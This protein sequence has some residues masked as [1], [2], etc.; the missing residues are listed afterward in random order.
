MYVNETDLDIF[1]GDQNAHGNAKDDDV[2]VFLCYNVEKQI[3]FIDLNLFPR[4]YAS[5]HVRLPDSWVLDHIHA[6]F[7]MRSADNK[8]ITNSEYLGYYRLE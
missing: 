1:W 5:A 3:V 7:A 2:A 4:S 6:W 8:L